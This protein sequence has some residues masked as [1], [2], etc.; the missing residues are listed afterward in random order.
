MRGTIRHGL[1]FAGGIA[2]I[3]IGMSASAAASGPAVTRERLL[4]CATS[5]AVTL[6]AHHQQHFSGHPFY[7]PVRSAMFF[8]RAGS[9]CR[10]KPAQHRQG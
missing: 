1:A 2:V 3:G 8:S 5:P 10:W 4:H 7:A 9:A 6:S